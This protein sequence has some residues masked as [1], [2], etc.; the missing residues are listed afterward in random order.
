MIVL[1]IS[2]SCT[3]LTAL[4]VAIRIVFSSGIWISFF[5]SYSPGHF[6]TDGRKWLMVF[7][8]LT[9]CVCVRIKH[10]QISQQWRSDMSL[11]SFI[12]R[13]S[14]AQLVIYSRGVHEC[15][16]ASRQLNLVIVLIVIFLLPLS[17]PL[18][19]VSWNY[20]NNS[21]NLHMY[22][23]TL[24]AFVEAVPKSVSK[25]MRF[26]ILSGCYCYTN[27]RNQFIFVLHFWQM[28][29]CLSQQKDY[30]KYF[31]LF[32]CLYLRCDLSI[33]LLFEYFFPGS[34]MQMNVCK[35]CIALFRMHKTAPNSWRFFISFFLFCWRCPYCSVL[36]RDIT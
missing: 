16:I 26:V 8:R 6:G 13:M 35:T 3:N 14:R 24:V 23:W 28:G 19:G 34:D 33:F 12:F 2:F 7:F 20:D 18:L 15:A 30:I 25:C 17:Y 32:Y 4:V 10:V 31:E 29:F 1:R 27:L 11:L 5:I 9:V 36:D 22:R 21:L